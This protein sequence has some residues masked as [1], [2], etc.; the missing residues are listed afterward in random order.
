MP[1]RNQIQMDES[2]HERIEQIKVSIAQEG[3]EVI[4]DRIAQNYQA[5]IAKII[6]NFG[7]IDTPE[8]RR[9]K[10]ERLS[11]QEILT[12]AQIVV[13]RLTYMHHQ[14]IDTE[15]SIQTLAE[16]ENAFL[17]MGYPR[18]TI[19]KN[20]HNLYANLLKE[21][22]ANGQLPLTTLNSW[23]YPITKYDSGEIIEIQEHYFLTYFKYP[24]AF[25]H[26]LKRQGKKNNNS[27]QDA[28]AP[29]I[30]ERYLETTTKL[31]QTNSY[32]TLA[33]GIAAAT[34][35]R[36]SEIIARGEIEPIGLY[37]YVFQGQLKKDNPEAYATFSLVPVSLVRDAIALFR[38]LPQI[39]PLKQASI[40]KLNVLNSSINYQ[41]RKHYQDPGII[42]V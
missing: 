6:A 5:R 37:K 12:L 3:W 31:L 17:E 4:R 27:K 1:R 26:M 28:P 25:Y 7:A 42:G 13:Q 2:E 41:V 36:Y 39:A 11:K 19:A 29:I 38:E 40:K 8:V 24:P 32:T 10:P 33:A 20:F 16:A 30:L 14:G 23:T 9:K 15:A 35:R 22:I 34:G 21:A 18:E